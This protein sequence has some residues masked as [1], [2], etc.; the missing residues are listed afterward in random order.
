MVFVANH[1][2][3]ID[4]AVILAA[5]PRH[6]R[7][8]VVTA[9][10]KDFFAPHFHPE[11]HTRRA[12]FTNGLAYYLATAFFN[13]FPLPQREA[14]AR[15]ALRYA[16]ELI[17]AG[18][19]LV[20][21]PEGRRTVGDAIARF[22]P[23]AAMIAAR[24]AVPVVPVRL[25]GIDTVLGEGQRMARPGRVEVRFGPHLRLSGGDHAALAAQ[26]EAAVKGL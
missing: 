23:G 4:P 10:A 12:R 21:F 7:Y 9:M 8:R 11:G 13:A 15:H 3:F 18:N 20:I 6:R 17:G 14:G 24:L 26:L 25:R 1:Q 16:G 2:S 5:L 22:Q 19:S